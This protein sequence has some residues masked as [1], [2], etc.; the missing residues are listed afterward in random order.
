MRVRQPGL[1]AVVFALGA[2]LAFAGPA[3]AQVIFLPSVISSETAIFSPASGVGGSVV[4]TGSPSPAF[5]S[6]PFSF[7]DGQGLALSGTIRSAVFSGGAAGANNT[8]GARYDF[9]YQITL[10]A[11]S[12]ALARVSLSNFGGF[13]T[14]LANFQGDIDGAGDF[15]ASSA[16]AGTAQRGAGGNPVTFNFASFRSSS[17]PG[18][19][20]SATLLVRTSATAFA[21]NG[22]A[23]LQGAT[24]AASAAGA[25]LVPVTAAAAPE[26]AGAALAGFC[27]LG[28]SVGVRRRRGGVSRDAARSR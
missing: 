28:V 20:S 3:H 2:G 21:A 5:L 9:Y 10:D 7:D 13:V 11:G 25:V 14:G 8:G 12:D 6:S 17:V 22:V 23:T 4:T 16:A 18:G 15:V 27:V 24:P 19:Q 26:P 1:P